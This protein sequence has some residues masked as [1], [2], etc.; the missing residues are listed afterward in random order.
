MDCRAGRKAGFLR[1]HVSRSSRSCEGSWSP[2]PLDHWSPQARAP[3]SQIHTPDLTF[4]Y[5]FLYFSE[6]VI[7]VRIIAASGQVTRD[8]LIDTGADIALFDEMIASDLGLDLSHAPTGVI[9]GVGGLLRDVRIAEVRIELLGHKDLS[10]LVDVAFAPDVEITSGNL[11]GRDVLEHFTF[12]LEHSKRLG[13][14][15][16]AT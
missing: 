4:E 6:P 16:R 2:R 12:G 14:L 1:R 5:S 3:R 10:V 15:G 8:A 7:P 13:Y 9:S 11:L